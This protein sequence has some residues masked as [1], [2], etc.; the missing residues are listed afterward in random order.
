MGR[1]VASFLAV[2]AR[3]AASPAHAQLEGP[4]ASNDRSADWQ[5]RTDHDHFDYRDYRVRSLDLGAEVP[6][7]RHHHLQAAGAPSLIAHNA[8]DTNS[9]I[10]RAEGT[11][12][13]PSRFWG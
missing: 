4:S 9:G 1:V 13:V 6:R 8:Q 12:Q 7:G 5:R 3:L 2:A 10:F 11:S